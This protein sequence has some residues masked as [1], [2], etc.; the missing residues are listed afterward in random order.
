M[1]TQPHHTAST[2]PRVQP[3][4]RTIDAI[5]GA[6]P[7]AQHMA[8]YREISPAEAGET[9]NGILEKWW[10]EAMFE[11]ADPRRAERRAT[12][13]ESRRLHPLPALYER[14]GSDAL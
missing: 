14:A 5:A 13:P 1:S 3:T 4:P 6:L 2:D 7:P 9:L 11:T 12:P 8:F 10:R